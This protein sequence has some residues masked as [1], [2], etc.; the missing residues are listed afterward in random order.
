MVH[1][2]EEIPR[3]SALEVLRMDGFLNYFKVS[4]TF[5]HLKAKA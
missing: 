3:K 5:H 2:K 1:R 4:R